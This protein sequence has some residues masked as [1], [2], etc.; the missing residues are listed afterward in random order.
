MHVIL[1]SVVISRFMK[2]KDFFS[3][4]HISIPGNAQG[5]YKV[6]QWLHPTCPKAL[7]A[8][9]ELG[10]HIHVLH[11]GGEHHIM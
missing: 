4:V 8:F 1:E 2:K 7:K 3:F 10:A 6:L 5:P 11:L 9:K